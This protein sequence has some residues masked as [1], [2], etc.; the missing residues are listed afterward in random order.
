MNVEVI[1]ELGRIDQGSCK[2]VHKMFCPCETYEHFADTAA[3][4]EV[5]IMENLFINV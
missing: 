5:S 4:Y 3:K 2:L 1:Q